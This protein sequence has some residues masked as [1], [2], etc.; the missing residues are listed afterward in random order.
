MDEEARDAEP[1]KCFAQRVEE[2]HEI[3]PQN[4]RL[5]E[6][7]AR[8]LAACP[9]DSLRDGNRA[10]KIAS[11]VVSTERTMFTVEAHAMSLAEMGRFDEAVALQEECLAVAQREARED[12]QVVL[13]RNMALYQ[14]Q[15]PSRRPFGRG[16]GG[17]GGDLALAS[18]ER[19]C[20]GPRD[21]D[22]SQYKG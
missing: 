5:A 8:L 21:T 6:A 16:E 17:R 11:R 18:R 14:K 1:G 10:L 20:T 2:G 7:L 19:G 9:V 15:L 4:V 13:K 22:K 3:L 12:L